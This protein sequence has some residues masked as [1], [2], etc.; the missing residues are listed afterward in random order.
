MANTVEDRMDIPELVAYLRDTPFSRSCYKVDIALSSF[1]Q[2]ISMFTHGDEAGVYESR[3]ASTERFSLSENPSRLFECVPPFQRKNDK[4]TQKMQVGFIE[5]ILKGFKTT[6]MFYEIAPDDL[7]AV[8]TNCMVLDGL[9]RLTAIH[10]FITGKL[11][12]FGY[13]Y[14]ELIKHRSMRMNLITIK[15]AD[16]TFS[17]EIEAVKFYID[18]NEG[19][20]HSEADINRAKVYLQELIDQQSATQP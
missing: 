3:A 12:V 10:D 4:W 2:G 17:S 9:Q 5:N 18:I 20:T 15:L 6:L 8:R 1:M 16:Y 13:T 19:V 7:H 11:T 14:D